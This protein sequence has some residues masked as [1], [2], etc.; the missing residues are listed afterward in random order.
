MKFVDS[1][2]PSGA[3]T[4]RFVG[5]ESSN[6]PEYG[7]G[8]KF[9]FEVVGGEFHGRKISVT[10]PPNPTPKNKTGRLINSLLGKSHSPGQDADVDQCV[11]REYQILVGPTRSGDSTTIIEVKNPTT[12][13]RW[14][15]EPV[16]AAAN[17]VPF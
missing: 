11:G 17:G 13:N 15:P 10:G 8:A 3:Y 4:A 16:A 5:V 1:S 6:H 2:L 12:T 14:G 9:S 7:A